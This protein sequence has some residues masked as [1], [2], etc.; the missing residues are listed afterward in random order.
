MSGYK[1]PDQ[2]TVE[3]GQ[4]V[5]RSFIFLS[6]LVDKTE[7][8]LEHLEKHLGEAF[9]EIEKLKTV[10]VKRGFPLKTVAVLGLGFYVGA[11][12]SNSANRAKLRAAYLEAADKVQDVANEVKNETGRSEESPVTPA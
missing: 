8:R 3:F 10:A 9:G 12:L 4:K 11:K 5:A 7:F 2:Y 6:D 1:V